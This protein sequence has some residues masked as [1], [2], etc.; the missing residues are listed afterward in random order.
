LGFLDRLWRRRP[1]RDAEPTHRT[2]LAMLALR[3]ELPVSFQR[4]HEH[5]LRTWPD[6][7]QPTELD[8][9][10]QA[11]VVRF[12]A[13]SITLGYM[14]MPIPWGDLE[15]PTRM[16][17]QWP[18][19]REAL[20]RHS[21][22]II[23]AVSSDALTQVEVTLLLTRVTAAA[24]AVADA[25]GVYY[26]NASLVIDPEH[27]VE[28]AAEGSS[29]HLPIFLWIGFHPV[30]E[31]A[32]LSAY[33]TGMSVFGYLELEAHETTLSPDE[34]LGRL[35]DIVHYQL[36]TGARLED[37]QTFGATAEE[38][39]RICHAPSRFIGDTVVCQLAL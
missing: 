36:S 6:V 18:G 1:K 33:T 9:G 10:E 22:H 15:W 12:P 11:A 31:S 25:A 8:E 32:G 24:A 38:R 14:P 21:A 7:P 20:E 3:T 17:W 5:L 23:I 28:Q 2:N 4:L 19:A 34:L 30:R 13:G 39:I 26:G 35:A 37:G 16:A 29:E 27:Y